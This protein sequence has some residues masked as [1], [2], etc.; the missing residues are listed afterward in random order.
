MTRTH[1]HDERDLSR[2]GTEIVVEDVL[3]QP[4][5]VFADRP[6]HL[7]ELLHWGDRHGDRTH[8][9]HSEQRFSFKEL[10]QAV[11]RV[12]EVLL[13]AG[14]RPGDPVLLFGANSLAWVTTFW[15]CLRDNLVIVPGNAWWS[16]E[17]AEHAVHLLGVRV[18]VADRRRAERLPAGVDVVGLESIMDNAPTGAEPVRDPCAVGSED[19]PAMVL[20]TSGTTSFPRG[21]TL[22]HRSLLGNLHN[23]LAVGGRLPGS[24]DSDRH[25]ATTLITMP[26]FHIGAIQQLFT[27][28]IA[29][30]S[31]VFLNGRFDAEQVLK[32]IETERVTGWSAVPTMVS[33]VLDVIEAQPGRFDVST[34]RTMAIGGAPVAESLRARAGEGFP[35]TK[36]G[37]AA[38]Y[39]LTELSGVATGAAGSAVTERPGT[40]GQ[41]LRTVD[42]RIADPDEAGIGEVLVRSP[43]VMIGYWGEPD[44]PILTPDRWLRTGD[45]GRMDGQGFLFLEGRIKEVIIRGGE[46]I[47]G[48]RVEERLLE[49]PSVAE[50]AVVGLPHPELGEEV[51]AAIVIHPGREVET[52][53]LAAF[54]ASTLSH[55]S[56][57]TAWW[58]V[59]E[60]PRNAA[61]KVLKQRIVAVWAAD[62]ATT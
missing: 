31:L 42:V 30:G 1:R 49:H 11:D 61:G 26:L 12:S 9:V 35:N 13:R 20:F 21:A 25:P 62:G 39:G 56:V 2:W 41:P 24:P 23:L 60:L 16:A 10:G 18:V 40:V 50:V 48:V 58:F 51:A 59:D 5:R 54:A 57:P 3:G 47:A 46:N 53:E 15:A 55:F 27:A 33:R 4:C 38:S 14:V 17:E 19:D 45:L 8:L 29:G 22:S 7:S 44:D 28:L 6:H 43:G 37:L 32:L 36:R 34:L 52:G